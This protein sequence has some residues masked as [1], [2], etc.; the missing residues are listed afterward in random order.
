MSAVKLA[1][2]NDML[3]SIKGGG[4]SVAGR[5]VCD[6]GLMIDLSLMNDVKVD[7]KARVAHVGP[8]ARL[9]DLD[10]ATQA[11]GL[12]T[13]GGLVSETGVA[14]LTLGGG[15]G[16]LA[17]RF[18]LTIDNLISADVVTADGKL[19][20]ASEKENP[21]LFWGLRGGGGNFGVVTSFEFKLH[22]VG[23][24]VL[25][26]Q[27]FYPIE[28]ASRVLRTY[29]EFMSKAPNEMACYSLVANVPPVEPFP[30][31]FHGKTSIAMVACYS[32]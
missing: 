10:R 27:I 21:E 3:V 26:A 32:G 20:H 15:M 31:E 12:A 9:A 14:G 5:G 25:V 30:E 2:E 22:E 8:G 16:Y 17:R 24:E 1:R 18:G 6:N 29:R 19:I 23:P 28:S 13:T 4:H 11:H 7:P